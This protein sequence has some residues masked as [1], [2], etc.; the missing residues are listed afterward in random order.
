MGRKIRT[1]SRVVP[2]II[3]GEPPSEPPY[4]N[5]TA[6]WYAGDAWYL[7]AIIIEKCGLE[8]AKF[9]FEKCIKEGTEIEAASAKR[10][11]ATQ[12]RATAAPMKIPTIK[13]IKAADRDRICMWYARLLTTDQHLSLQEK[14]SVA[15]LTK[16]Y[17]EFGGFP[18][19]FVP[20]LPPIK[21]KGA[22]RKV[23]P[24]AAELPALFTALKIEHPR[25][26]NPRIAELIV[27]RYGKKYGKSVEAVERAEREW[28][29]KNRKV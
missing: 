9:I 28:R 29:K 15:L 6:S 17:I 10:A 20:R 16:R 2:S 7:F 11:A 14:K 23:R 19:D 12:R 24:A 8:T 22:T 1:I 13:E 26:N 5:P 4:L 18:A 25:L 21:K 27:E 3:E